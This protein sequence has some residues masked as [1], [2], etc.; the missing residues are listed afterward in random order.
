M[1]SKALVGSFP[2]IVSTLG[3]N[4]IPAGGLLVAG[5]SAETAMVIYFLENIV[6]VMLAA[7]RVLIIP[8]VRDAAFTK[9]TE[10]R[11][12][13]VKGYVL[14]ALGSSLASAVFLSGFIFLILRAEI[15]FQ[16][17][18]AGM[19]GSSPSNSSVSFVIFCCCAR[20][21]SRAPKICYSRVWVEFFCFTSPCSS[22]CSRQPS[23]T[24]GSC[25]PSSRSKLRWT[26]A[27]RLGF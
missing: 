1:T 22:E 14:V 12:T 3:V 2:S 18:V 11:R 10:D 17:I 4:A 20:Y 13:L 5:W 19:T 15:P 21:H 24:D 27:G 23:P 9:N 6:A 26:W 8:S 7:A 16:T 25:F